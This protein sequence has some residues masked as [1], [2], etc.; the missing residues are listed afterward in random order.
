MLGGDRY[1][2]TILQL[3]AGEDEWRQM[4]VYRTDGGRIVEVWLYEEP[5]QRTSVPAVR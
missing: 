2:A 4:A 5:H 1:A 3:E